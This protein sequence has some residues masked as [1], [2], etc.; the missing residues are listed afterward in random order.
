MSRFI[1]FL[2]FF[3][4]LALMSCGT[5]DYGP[6]EDNTGVQP[7]VGEKINA[8]NDQ[9]IIEAQREAQGE[10]QAGYIWQGLKWVGVPDEMVSDFQTHLADEVKTLNH[11]EAFGTAVLGG[12]V[13]GLVIRASDSWFFGA[14]VDSKAGHWFWKR[15]DRAVKGTTQGLGRGGLFAGGCYLLLSGVNSLRYDGLLGGD[16]SALSSAA[17]LGGMGAGASLNF[18]NKMANKDW[19][20]PKSKL[21]QYI[22][23]QKYVGKGLGKFQEWSTTTE[24]GKGIRYKLIPGVTVL[25][26]GSGIGLIVYNFIQDEDSEQ[27]T[28]IESIATAPDQ[29]Q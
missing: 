7:E 5:Q 25:G 21:G 20:L 13:L 17:V 15:M 22:Y 18:I 10:D 26:I 24:I 28:A 6:Y 9:R 23:S 19:S 2:K 4:V 29:G 12:A 1:L 8:F 16:F 3:S 11:F 14:P 27:L